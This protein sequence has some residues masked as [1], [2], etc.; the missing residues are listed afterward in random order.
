MMGKP[1]LKEKIAQHI[2]WREHRLKDGPLSINRPFAEVRAMLDKI[3][4]QDD[5]Q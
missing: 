3:E 5:E 2:R 4:G 1:T